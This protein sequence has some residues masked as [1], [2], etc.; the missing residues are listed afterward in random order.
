MISSQRSDTEKSYLIENGKKKTNDE[1]I[2]QNV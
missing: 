2:R 1:I